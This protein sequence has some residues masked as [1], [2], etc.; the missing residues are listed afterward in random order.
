MIKYAIAFIPT[1]IVAAILSIVSIEFFK[2]PEFFIGW[3]SCTVW[4]TVLDL[5]RNK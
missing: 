3:A 5:I 4:Y 2:I 1:I